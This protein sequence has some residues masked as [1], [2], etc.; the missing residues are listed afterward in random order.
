[1][2]KI[3]KKCL[4][5]WV[6]DLQTSHWLQKSGQNCWHSYYWM[7]TNQ[8][9]HISV[10]MLGTNLGCTSHATQ[11]SWLTPTPTAPLWGHDQLLP[12]RHGDHGDHWVHVLVSIQASLLSN[13]LP[14]IN[15]CLLEV[16][17]FWCFLFHM[18]KLYNGI[19]CQPDKSGLHQR[20]TASEDCWPA[21]HQW[22]KCNLIAHDRSVTKLWCLMMLPS[23]Q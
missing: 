10:H 9:P 8:I 16:R 1:M 2:I 5:H 12:L 17:V 23:I 3:L 7:G 11:D 19:P 4:W 18:T 13:R 14:G 22:C 6:R 15:R 21:K 20:H